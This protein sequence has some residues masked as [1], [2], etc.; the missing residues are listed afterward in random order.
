MRTAAPSLLLPLVIIFALVFSLSV[1]VAQK[2]ESRATVVLAP[3]LTLPKDTTPTLTAP[4]F[5][6]F[7]MATGLPLVAQDADQVVPIASVT[8]LFAAATL[9]R[10]FDLQSTTS[11]TWS[12]IDG[13][14]GAGKLAF[15]QTYSYQNLLFPLLIES[16]NDAARVLARATEGRLVARMNIWASTIRATQ[17][18]FTDAS[19]LSDT[20]VSSA[21][22]LQL[23]LT[24]AFKN[25]SH[26]FDISILPQYIG[27]Y[28]GWLNNNPVAATDGFRGGKN[29]YTTAAGR[30]LVA[31]FDE[32][33]NGRDY[34]LG[35]IILGSTD[36][37][38]DTATLRS[39]ITSSASVR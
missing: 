16:S 30:T 7:D 4:I 18:V 23:L 21:S 3:A 27:S 26:V 29:G 6:V 39:F 24:A 2:F 14:G 25:E 38:A 8:K 17:T 35:Y 9:V 10:E 31:I 15:G 28:T 32:E 13:G 33:V 37:A 11:I 34:T 36:I 20:N 19:G 5:L 1:Y 12:D 22:D